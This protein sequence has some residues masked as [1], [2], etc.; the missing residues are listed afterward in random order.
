MY[1]AK[2]S[3]A[4]QDEAEH[5]YQRYKITGVFCP[6]ATHEFQVPRSVVECI[7]IAL[8]YSRAIP[9][10]KKCTGGSEHCSV[11]VDLKVASAAANKHV[12]SHPDESQSIGG[13]L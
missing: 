1:N 10:R 13:A 11:K 9:C 5:K 7:P 3:G 2:K 6:R 8:T 12:R 4:T